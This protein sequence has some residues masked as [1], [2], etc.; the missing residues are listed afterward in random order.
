M[1]LLPTLGWAV[2]LTV[3]GL[4]GYGL[5]CAALLATARLPRE[6]VFLVL[7]DLLF[8]LTLP[9]VVVVVA[10]PAIRRG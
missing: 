3:L 9:F 6:G 7:E 2:A 5:G 8:L 10:V 4:V 1:G